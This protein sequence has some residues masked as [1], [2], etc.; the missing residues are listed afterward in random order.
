MTTN[1]NNPPSSSPSSFIKNI[2][3]T[4][5][6]FPNNLPTEYLDLY[7]ENLSNVLEKMNLNFSSTT[8]DVLSLGALN[9][10]NTLPIYRGKV[11]KFI[12]FCIVIGDAESTLIFLE[13]SPDKCPSANSRTIA[14]FLRWHVLEEGENLLDLN[15]QAIIKDA[16]G[17]DLKCVGGWNEMNS[18]NQFL[19]AVT[20][21]H[22]QKD[23]SGDYVDI[24]N[25]CVNAW[26]VNSSSIGCVQH[27]YRRKIFRSG[28]PRNSKEVK[29]M[30][31]LIGKEVENHV[32]RG[33][34]QLLPKEMRA[35]RKM[36]LSTNKKED[37]QCWV[38]ILLSVKMYLR[39]EEVCSIRLEHFLKEWF[40]LDETSEKV[41]AL[42]VKVKGKTDDDWLRFFIYRSDDCPEFCAMRHL[43]VYLHSC[44]ITGDHGWLF[45][46]LHA[47]SRH[48]PYEKFLRNMRVRFTDLLDR[49]LPLTCHS[50]RKTG[51][52]FAIWG[53]ARID[54]I[55][56]DARH[57][58]TKTSLAYEQDAV[59]ML[60]YANISNEN[61]K[62]EVPRYKA[63]RVINQAVGVMLSSEVSNVRELS[64]LAK[65]YVERDLRVAPV[66]D[67][68]RTSFILMTRAEKEVVEESP[69]ISLRELMKAN[70]PLR[71]YDDAI[72]L[73]GQLC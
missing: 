30:I 61:A 38:M 13:Q 54:V 17:K 7:V 70:M 43:L 66:A 57:M 12:Y 36:L 51:Y 71:K 14:L 31:G 46:S 9:K 52:L 47:R 21:I 29:Q 18:V 73:L 55:R 34:Y 49:R 62:Y 53:D 4:S 63:V 3:N 24:C 72:V 59:S 56:L 28:N 48:V 40:V 67:F 8:R 10:K 19:S 23:Q 16:K 22:T 64:S 33:A 60:S 58:C 1:N 41:K 20:T 5:S 37:L 65:L 15:N 27:A 42:A 50:L 2:I 25:D 11:R 26:L 44:E 69:L 32:V 6:V 45:P 68:Y 39:A 35:I